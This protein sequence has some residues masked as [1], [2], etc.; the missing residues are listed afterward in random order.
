LNDDEND[1]T[2]LS[3]KVLPSLLESPNAAPFKQTL[4]YKAL[5]IKKS[6]PATC[7]V[8][9]SCAQADGLLQNL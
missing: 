7:I 2:L 1:N 4:L 5:D 6:L 3:L 8:S 9:N